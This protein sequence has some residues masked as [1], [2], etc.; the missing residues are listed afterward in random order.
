MN[1]K[2]MTRLLTLITLLLAAVSSAW[3]QNTFKAD[4]TDLY[5]GR[6]GEI[7]FSLTNSDPVYGL[8]AQITCPETL[9]FV[10]TNGKPDITLSSR[11][12]GFNITSNLNDGKLKIAILSTSHEPISGNSGVLL[13][14]KVKPRN[15]VSGTDDIIV[16]N[17]ILTNAANQ[18][19]SCDGGTTQIS[20][21]PVPV[22]S[23]T[24]SDATWSAQ[25]GE[26]V[27][28]TA[29]VL[30]EDAADKS[31]TW[32]SSDETIATVDADGKVTAVSVG[33]ATITA[34]AADESGV[35]AECTVTVI[36]TPVASITLS[37]SSWSGKVGQTTN[38]TA[39]VAPD[40]ATDKSLT[41][42]SNDESIATVDSDGKVTA[43]KVGEAT[44]TATS[45]DESGVKA[46]CAVTVI[47][48]PVESITLST[49][50]WSGKVGESTTLSATILP[51]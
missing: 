16:D 32:T 26:S 15:E 19:V 5:I 30:P 4:P 51:E 50:S 44:I 42:S 18:D 20:V 38:L 29:T 2:P 8:Q 33:E 1:A 23:I 34:T 40:N 10:E 25:V 43:V 45:A 41:W 12:Q 3:S 27:T 6:T 9:D 31:L 28:L 48:T 37:S 46:E 36:P 13:S 22:E 39:T 7:E 47:P 11:A 14:I 24:L 49:S 21:I 35:K 17:V